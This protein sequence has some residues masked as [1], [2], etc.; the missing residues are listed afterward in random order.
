MNGVVQTGLG[1]TSKNYFA[2]RFGL[3]IS[4]NSNATTVQQTV[5]IQ[6]LVLSNVSST[7]SVSMAVLG[8]SFTNCIMVQVNS[9]YTNTVSSANDCMMLS[10]HVEAIHLSDLAW[11]TPNALPLVMSFYVYCANANL[12]GTYAAGLRNYTTNVNP[13]IVSSFT[14]T[15]LNSWQRVVLTFPGNTSVAWPT[16]NSLGLSL[17]ITLLAPSTNSVTTQGAWQSGTQFGVA[18]MSNFMATAENTMYFTGVQLEKGTLVTPFE[19]RPYQTELRF[20]QRYCTQ[21]TAT[22]SNQHL[23]PCTGFSN[24]A[25][26]GQ[27]NG[28][29]QYPQPMRAVPTLVT[30]I[31][32]NFATGLGVNLATVNGSSS[33]LINPLDTSSTMASLQANYG[34]T[35]ITTPTNF[36]AYYTTS[37][38]GQYL[39]F[40]AEI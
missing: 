29:Y 32:S 23:V 19:Y 17:E 28:L 11:G 34:T 13:T 9:P 26:G 8:Q 25:T 40:N 39:Q 37:A 5:N 15:T 38:I 33:M 24:S 10:H 6:Q 3:V 31:G 21:L 2:D 4:Q 14:V 36:S 18:G 27:L 7:S 22:N 35:S 16:D 30:N 20:C 12:V 1:N